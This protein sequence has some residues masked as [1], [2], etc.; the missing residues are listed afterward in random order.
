M[1]LKK[2]YLLL[3]TLFL[4]ATAK[5][6]N[7]EDLPLFDINE[8]AY[9]GA[10]RVPA[11]S[12][13]NSSMNY[14]QGPICYN[15][16]NHSI[17]IVGHAHHQEVAE[18]EIPGI[19]NSEE[20]SDLNMADPPL[21]T[22]VPF[23]DSTTDG[24]PENIDRIGGMFYYKAANEEKLILNAF[25][26]YDAAANNTLT[27]IIVNEADDL[28]NSSVDGYLK[29]EGGAGHTSGW[30]SPVPLE[31]QDTLESNYITGQSSGQPIIARFSVGPSAFG[32]KLDDLLDMTD[33][34][35]TNK[36]LDFDLA[37]ALNSDLFNESLT[38]DLWT[39]LSRAT[40]GFIVPGTRTYA[41][42]GYSGGHASGVCYKCEQNNGVVCGGYCA[43]DTSDY[44]QYYW[45]W[46]MNDL[47]EVKAG[48]LNSYDVVPY[49]YGVFETPF[50][51]EHKE[52]GGGSYDPISG[53]LYLTIQKADNGQSTYA[54][55]PV[56]VVYSTKTVSSVDVFLSDNEISLYPNPTQDVFEIRG[57]ISN[58][59][60]HIIDVLGNIYQ[61][62]TSGSDELD[63]DISNLPSGI[64]FINIQSN[65]T[66][67][68]LLKKI[69]KQ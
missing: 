20:L 17:Y 18:F 69:I 45:L 24:N 41:T 63:I 67:D 14:S 61:S 12:F 32:F 19:I 7:L 8:L 11:S 44:D 52:I 6:Q 16:K 4:F 22:F 43:I 68:V 23:L 55:P 28:S 33:P 29:F 42:L 3:L 2:T 37:N 21:Q 34:I 27:T 9:E 13:G 49:D 48:N 65:T 56:I 5:T 66:S 10:F 64:Y 62:F 1:I 39:H 50:Q 59:N 60:I 36:M 57:P 38:N 40:Y 31:W 15:S 58:Y 51:N 25:E 46:D 26:Y 30:I 53:N 47:L 35:P 54:N